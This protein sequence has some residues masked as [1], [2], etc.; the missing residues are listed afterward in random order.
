MKHVRFYALT[1]LTASRIPLAATYLF[2]YLDTSIV[3]RQWSFLVLAVALVTDISDG[4]IARR[5]QLATKFGYLLDGIADRATY[6]AIILGVAWRDGLSLL[7]GYA[8]IVRDLLLY[9]TRAYY[10]RWNTTL[11]R[12]RRVAKVHALSVRVMLACYLVSDAASLLRT[13]PRAYIAGALPFLTVGSVLVVS[14]SYYSLW[15]L[16]RE[17]SVLHASSPIDELDD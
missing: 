14:A 13:P 11:R 10:P 8:L 2:L 1:C 9:G 15:V 7:L 5:Y 16:I 4:R 12:Q 3:M 6:I 17:Q